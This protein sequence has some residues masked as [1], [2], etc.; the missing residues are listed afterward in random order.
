MH[1]APSN[2]FFYVVDFVFKI[3]CWTYYLVETCRLKLRK[4]Y[5]EKIKHEKEKWQTVEEEEMTLYFSAL[6]LERL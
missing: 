6:E 2:S 5:L 3:D 4:Q 1:N